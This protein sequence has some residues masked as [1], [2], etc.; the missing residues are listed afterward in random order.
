MKLREF[1]FNSIFVPGL[2]VIEKGATVLDRGK[3]FEGYIGETL[4]KLPRDWADKEIVDTRVYF[5][6]FVI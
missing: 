1:N 5:D 3:C 6:M 4:R 2:C